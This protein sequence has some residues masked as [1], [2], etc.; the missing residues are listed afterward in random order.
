MKKTNA[1]I[2]AV[3]AA[4]MLTACGGTDTAEVTSAE[5]TVS[6]TTGSEVTEATEA[7]T[8]T[9]SITD[10]VTSVEP[11]E[12]VS[13][14]EA[15]EKAENTHWDTIVYDIT[16]RCDITN[17]FWGDDEVVDATPEWQGKTEYTIQEALLLFDVPDVVTSYLEEHSESYKSRVDDNTLIRNISVGHKDFDLDG[18]VE[19]FY[20]VNYLYNHGVEIVICRDD[21]VVYWNGNGLDGMSRLRFSNVGCY[22]A[23]DPITDCAVAGADLVVEEH[24]THEGENMYFTDDNIFIS[25]FWAETMGSSIWNEYFRVVSDAGEYRIEYV[26]RGSWFSNQDDDDKIHFYR[27]A[28]VE[29][30]IPCV[31]Q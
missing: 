30:D 27:T 6:E 3:L 23:S 9:E 12:S 16:S 19:D 8:L 25:C 24:I 1:L 11:V 7:T 20:A 31:L 2:A 28:V 10:G 18:V 13:D 29:G 26:G 22:F 15:I 17:W 5:S 4:S 14:T 21:E